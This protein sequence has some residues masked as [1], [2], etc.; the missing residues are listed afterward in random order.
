MRCL[1][2]ITDEQ[3]T[4]TIFLSKENYD[5]L[6]DE[7]NK[8]FNMDIKDMGKPS[9]E[10]KS[11]YQV[12]VQPPPRTVTLKRI[13]HEYTLINKPYIAP[14]DFGITKLDLSKY[15]AVMY[16]KDSISHDMSVKEKNIDHLKDSVQYSAFSLA[17]E[18]ARYLNISCLLAD[19]I[20]RE[21]TDGIETILEA[22]NNF[23]TIL[24]DVIIPQVFHALFEVKSQI[25]SENKDL[26]LLRE[27]K[28]AGFYEF[29]AKDD[30]V[31]TNRHQ[32][33]KP[34]EV[35]KSFHADTYCFDSLPERE[36]FWQYIKSGKV[37]EVYFTGMFTGNQGDLAIQYYDPDSG[38]IRQ[39]Y[40]DFLAKM[41]DDSYQIIEVKGDNKIDD[42]VVNAK[43]AAARE[44][45]MASGVEY[46]MYA[47]SV[48]MKSRVLE[49]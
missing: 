4:A 49:Q 12:R 42:A 35:K 48:V 17:G 7:L 34:E 10:K 15:T 37:K 28:D 43:A 22:L 1:R 31:V 46:K 38:R 24:D 36:C 26:V 16:E 3:Q 2:K 11:R 25:R 18:V 40:P 13:W 6:D 5:T 8:N 32:G 27:P 30:L 20:L 44:M 47:G 23:N 14:V 41:N 29:S 45:A 21:A 19:S 39:Y 9:T 33:L